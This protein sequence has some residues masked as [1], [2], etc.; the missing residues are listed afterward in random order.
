MTAT[1]STLNT[2]ASQVRN[3]GRGVESQL[4]TA[5]APR[6]TA[7]TPHAAARTV[8]RGVSGIS[9][10]HMARVRH[11]SVLIGFEK[12]L[13]VSSPMSLQLPTMEDRL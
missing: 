5:A 11:L 1:V 2:Q 10:L 8:L 6:T 12:T 7:I 3:S 13:A 4:A 9:R